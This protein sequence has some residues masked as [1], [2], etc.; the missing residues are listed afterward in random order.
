MRQLTQRHFRQAILTDKRIPVLEHI[1]P[2]PSPDLAPCN[3][4]LFPKMKSAL[5]GMEVNL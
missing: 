5:K 1:P 2:C 3:F 4:Y